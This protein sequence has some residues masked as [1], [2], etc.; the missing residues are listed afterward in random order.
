MEK[1]RH[2]VVLGSRSGRCREIGLDHGYGI[3]YT[4]AICSHGHQVEDSPSEAVPR[5]TFALL[6]ARL[7]GVQKFGSQNNEH[8][9][10]K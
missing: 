9:Y 5:N 10:E 6:S 8:K 1:L 3:P 4:V 7:N 2:L